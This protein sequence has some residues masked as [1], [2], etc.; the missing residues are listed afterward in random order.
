[1]VLYQHNGIDRDGVLCMYLHAGG[2]WYLFRFC[3]SWNKLCFVHVLACGVSV[4]SV[5]SSFARFCVCL[6]SGGCSSFFVALDLLFCHIS[7]RMSLQSLC[8]G[9]L[10]H[11]P[12]Q[13]WSRCWTSSVTVC[14]RAIASR[15]RRSRA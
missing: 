2:E 11:V 15:L 5:K 9:H 8:F 1:M 14:R 6:P 3:T 7:H 13:A 10:Y 4:C 12:S